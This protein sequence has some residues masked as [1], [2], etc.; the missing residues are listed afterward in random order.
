L[1]EGDWVAAKLRPGNV[2]ATVGSEFGHLA[3]M[4]QG[5]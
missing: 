2:S 5:A 1:K 4:R 3:V